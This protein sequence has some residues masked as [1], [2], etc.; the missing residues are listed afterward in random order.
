[1]FTSALCIEIKLHMSIVLDIYQLQWQYDNDLKM[2]LPFFLF[3][4]ILDNLKLQHTI[5]QHQFQW[6]L[7]AH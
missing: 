7:L 1:M 5:S 3:S 6:Q 4:L 2:C